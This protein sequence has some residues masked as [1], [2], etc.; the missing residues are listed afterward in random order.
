MRT[1][2]GDKR[3]GNWRKEKREKGKWKGKRRMKGRNTNLFI[4]IHAS[5]ISPLF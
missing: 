3:R 5:G 4:E 2:N 1:E